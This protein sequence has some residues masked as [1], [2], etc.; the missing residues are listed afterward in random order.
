VRPRVRNHGRSGRPGLRPDSLRG[1]TAAADDDHDR[2]G[3]VNVHHDFDVHVHIDLDVDVHVDLDDVGARW[4]FDDDGGRSHFD[5]DID[6]GSAD[7]HVDVHKHI[8]VDLYVDVNFHI[9]IDLYVDVNFHVDQHVDVHDDVR[10]SNVDN[11]DDR[12]GNARTDS[13][14][15]LEHER[16]QLDRETRI[17]E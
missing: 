7:F 4:H 17:R 10:T 14:I 13:R 12:R 16:L 6:R 9:H 11:D 5:H 2:R 15:G 1:S 3:D 8:H